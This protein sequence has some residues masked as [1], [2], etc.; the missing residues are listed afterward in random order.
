[1]YVKGTQTSEVRSNYW[2]SI[3]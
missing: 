1:M 2:T 3:L